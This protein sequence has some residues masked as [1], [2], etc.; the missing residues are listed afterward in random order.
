MS[1]NNSNKAICSIILLFAVL[2]SAAQTTTTAKAAVDKNRLLIGEQVQLTLEVNIPENE[3][4]RFFYI[5]TIPHFEFISKAVI[6]TTDTD[7]GTILRQIITITSFDSGHWV[8]PS[9]IL[10]DK[11]V[12]DSIPMDVVFSDFNPEQDYHDIKDIIEVEPKKEER[13]WWIWYAIGG[14]ALVL[15]LLITYLLRKKK[16]VPVTVAAPADPYADALSQLELVR[17]QKPETKQ[18]YSRLIDIFR[19][20]LEKRKGI[21]SLQKTTDDLVVQ[22]KSIPL[23]KEQFEKLSQSLRL[24]DF[25]KFAK[26]APSV[27]DD[28]NTFEIIKKTIGDIEQI[29]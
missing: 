13:K 9:F 4:I 25:V 8:I 5:D 14:G 29:K 15:I 2:L 10:G 24:A 20:Y 12:T 1:R 26:Y 22:L 27:E 7:D 6:D 23:E 16:P 19:V 3:P 18:Y 17:S 11:A 21:H 28:R